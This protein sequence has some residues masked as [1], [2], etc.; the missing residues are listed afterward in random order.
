MRDHSQA[1]TLDDGMSVGN[2][3]NMEGRET[4]IRSK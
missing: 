3:G 2:I 1:S 4:M